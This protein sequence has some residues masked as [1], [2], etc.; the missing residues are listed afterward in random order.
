MELPS[1][2]PSTPR[3]AL[4]CDPGQH[5]DVTPTIPPTSIGIPLNNPDSLNIN[6]LGP[7][8]PTDM[9]HHE[10]RYRLTEKI[11]AGA[12]SNIFK[13]IDEVTGNQVAVKVIEKVPHFPC[14]ADSE[15][16]VSSALTHENLVKCLGKYHSRL[17]THLVFEF[18]NQGDLFDRLESPDVDQDDE[19]SRLFMAQAAEGLR[20]IHTMGIVHFD[21]KLE[22]ML[23]HNNTIKLCDFGLSGVHGQV[24]V[25]KP[26]GTSAYMSPELAKIK[27]Q[28]TRYTVVMSADIWAFA[29]VLHT[30]I[31]AD[32]PWE[33]AVRCDGEY[34]G[35]VAAGVDAG[36]Q[37]PWC[38]LDPTFR[39]VLLRMLSATPE[40]R[41]NMMEVCAA[42][43][44]QW[45]N[46][47]DLSSMVNDAPFMFTDS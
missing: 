28:S 6:A 10:E 7:P 42:V 47:M 18:S 2:V 8:Y 30:V 16:A 36:L 1:D 29:I 22:N 13:A 43:Q 4:R 41:P 26:H 39:G 44:G 38:L 21:I 31:F 15:F 46:E 33:K 25:G 32:L 34:A 27:S 20:H 14:A 24:R 37:Q 17:R 11:G 12:F 35:F 9:V 5:L 19:Q 3:T 23:V 40:L 45:L